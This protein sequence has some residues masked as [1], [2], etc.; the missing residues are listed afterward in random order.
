ME[1]KDFMPA[2]YVEESVTEE[3]MSPLEKAI[4]RSTIIINSSKELIEEVADDNNR[5][6]KMLGSSNDM[7][8][9]QA[10]GVDKLCSELEDL[11]DENI[12]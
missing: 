10:I 11:L 6:R 7:L 2:G 5:I 1:I 8:D 9:V 4:K 12:D 3:A